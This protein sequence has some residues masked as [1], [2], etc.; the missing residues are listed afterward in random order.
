[1]HAVKLLPSAVLLALGALSHSFGETVQLSYRPTSAGLEL[2]WQ[3]SAAPLA[4]PAEFR[5]ETSE[6]LKHW[7]LRSRVILEKDRTAPWRAE[8]QKQNPKE[9]FRVASQFNVDLVR[10]ESAEVLGYD[11]VF[12]DFLHQVGQITP[13]QFAALYPDQAEYVNTLSWDP[14]EAAFFDLFNTTPES[15]GVRNFTLNDPEL[16]AYKEHGFVV[17]PRLGSES[18]GDTYYQIFVRDLP[19]FIT[20]DSMLHAWHKSFEAMLEQLED[21]YLYTLLEQ[22]LDGMAAA[23]PELA[24]E[25]DGPAWNESLRD[26][27]Y[28]LAVARTLLHGALAESHFGQDQL[29][30]ETMGAIENGNAI[31]FNLFGRLDRG[32]HYQFDFSQFKVRGHYENSERLKRYFQAMM[33]CGRVDLRIAGNPRE[34][35]PRELGTALLLS[36]LLD[37]SGQAENWSAFDQIIELFIGAKDSMDPRQM[38]NVRHIAGVDSL[39]QI[40]SLTQLESIQTAIQAG[41]YGIQQILSDLYPSPFGPEQVWLPRS[42]GLMG[43]RFT[44]DAWAMGKVAFDRI[45]WDGKKVPRRRVSSL[46]V[47]FGVLNND[48]PV[49]EILARIHDPAGHQFRD[50]FYYQH[51][52][53]GTRETIES[54]SNDVWGSS[55]YNQWLSTLRELSPPT[56]SPEYP[57]SMRTRAWALRRMNAQLGSWTQLRHDTVLYVKQTYVPPVLCFYP[58]GFVEPLPEF[59]ESLQQMAAGA[60][61]AIGHLE[62]E[63]RVPWQGR[64]DHKPMG[65]L[66]LSVMKSNQVQF[67]TRFATTA[68]SLKAMAEKE[69][70]Q[71]PFSEEEQW[72]IENVVE[73]TIRYAGERTFTGWYPTLFYR[74]NEGK[75]PVAPK[76]LKDH[77]SSQPVG[78]V[79]DVLT[80]GV[81]ELRGDPGAVLHEAVGNVAFMLVAVDNG[82]DRMTFAGPVYTYYEFERPL[83]DRLTD[84]QWRTML[85][86]R[87]QPPFPEWTEGWLVRP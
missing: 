23:L 53:A 22:I 61:T 11:G 35:A 26:A 25:L 43:Q 48:L 31:L 1:M 38:A 42:F 44:M 5:V 80:V 73:D 58:A 74:S 47:A 7:Q 8:F 65:E 30:G 87:Q 18:F 66:D 54:Q 29:L 12:Q 6:D 77:D 51:N 24:Q 49:L 63:G 16:A 70:A 56:T 59:W 17:S 75:D 40:S 55:I 62:M 60:A 71:Q 3:P 84:T 67:L 28:Y 86:N 10:A 4:A 68:E 81:D 32:L 50:G 46:D 83:N 9:F 20:A 64:A 14:T 57:E 27:D 34:S 69:L 33:W 78:L 85:S 36:E 79:T 15:W 82:P 13:E 76:P 19:V 45:L 72:L 2:S 52:L 37:R 39:A 21:A 41:N